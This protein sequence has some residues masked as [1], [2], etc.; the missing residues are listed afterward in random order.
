[1][2]CSTHHL[3]YNQI[4][5]VTQ[6]GHAIQMTEGLLAAMEFFWCKNLVSWSS[7]KQNVVS[8]SST[9]AEYHLM[10]L[11]TAKVYQLRMLFKELAISIVHI[12]TIWCDNI[13]AIALASNPVFHARTKH[14]KND[15]HFI[16]EKVCNNDIKVQ[17][18]STVDQVAD[19]FTK[20]QT[21][22]RFQ[23]LKSQLMV[24]QNPINSRGC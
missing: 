2:D 21:E 22:Q 19:V 11:S 12:P 4:P 20:G 8:H 13:G 7:K 5:T 10:A 17:H 16:R 6:I 9:E 1:M 15:Y 18:V 23:Y 24:C 3:L 14:V